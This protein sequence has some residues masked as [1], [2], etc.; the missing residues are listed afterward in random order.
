MEWRELIVDFNG[1]ITELVQRLSRHK[2]ADALSHDKK[3]IIGWLGGTLPSNSMDV[4]WV[5]RLALQNGIDLSRFQAFTPIYD[6]SPLLSY[7]ENVQ[8]E[9]MDLSWLTNTQPPPVVKTDFCGLELD[10]PLGVASSPLIANDRWAA[11]MLGLNRL[12][13][14]S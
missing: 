8:K 5:I 9:P 3:T 6:L 2:V 11:L 12:K 7:E 4:A 14:D 1:L 10:G 13:I